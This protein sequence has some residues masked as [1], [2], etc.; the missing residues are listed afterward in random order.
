MFGINAVFWGI[1]WGVIKYLINREAQPFSYDDYNR[2]LTLPLILMFVGFIGI[3][4]LILKRLTKVVVIASFCNHYWFGL[5]TDR[6]HVRIL[7]LFIDVSR[8]SIRLI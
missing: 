3:H 1:L 7:D 8:Y 6:K 4:T 5:I 2:M